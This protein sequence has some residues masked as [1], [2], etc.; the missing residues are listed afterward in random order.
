MATIFGANLSGATASTA[1][2]WVKTLGGTEVHLVP[3]YKGCGTANAPANLSCELE[4]DLI[5]VSPTQINFVVPDVS[6]SAYGQQELA[7]DVVFVENGQRFDSDTSF[8]VSP[9]GD[10]A[11][12]GVGYDCDFALSLSHPNSCG[13]SA[14][15]GQ[16][17][18]PIGAITDVS[19]NLVT[20]QNPVHQGQIIVLWATGL[21]D[22]IQQGDFLQQKNPDPITFGASQPKDG[23]GFN[24][25]NTAWKTVTPI[26]AGESPQYPGLDQINVPFP[27]C[28]GTAATSE[29]RYDVIL[30]F[31]SPSADSNLGIGFATLYMPFLISPGDP[32]C[33]FGAPITLSSSQN[34]SISGQPV[35]FTAILP[36]TLP[37]TV[38]FLDGSAA[39]G[40][41]PLIPCTAIQRYCTGP[42]GT[43]SIASITISN[44]S[45]GTHS[46]VVSYQGSHSPYDTSTSPVLTQTVLYSASLSVT[47]TPNPSLAGQTVT[48]TATVSPSI[49]TGAVIFFNGDSPNKTTLGTGTLSGGIATLTTANLNVGSNPIRVTYGGDASCSTAVSAYDNTPAT[50]IQTV[51]QNKVAIMLSSSP[52]PS[53]TGEMVTF[54]ACGLPVPTTGTVAFYDAATLLATN[55]SVYSACSSYATNTLSVGTHYIT[56]HYSG[57]STYNASVSQVQIQTVQGTTTMTLSSSVNPSVVGQSVRLHCHDFT[58]Y[59]HGYSY[60]QYCQ[61][62]PY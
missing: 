32:T 23:G 16:N 44:L 3:F 45:S 8:Y 53:V 52:N 21:G 25:L 26:W 11:V 15:P 10:F 54:T 30:S 51:T 27:S 41:Q 60:I 9:V 24:V 13:Y 2:P 33:H 1:P 56:A 38:T 18:V 7:L 4:A 57:N 46:I 31:Q 17:T 22:L 62:S 6:P 37:G 50:L 29:Q 59:C 61:Q 39:L 20:S 28:T 14:T 19:G 36:S 12:F 35:T 47:S 48:F 55:N 5:Y 40:T 34:S 43:G 58:V 42:S 49:C